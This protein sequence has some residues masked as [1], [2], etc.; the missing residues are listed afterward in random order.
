MTALRQ[1]DDAPRGFVTKAEHYRALARIEELED[2]LAES[3]G[4]AGVNPELQMRV[5]TRFG[6]TSLESEVLTLLMSHNELGKEYMFS[7]IW[8][9]GGQRSDHPEPKILD[10]Y[11]CKLRKR[12]A[13]KEAPAGIIETIWGKGWRIAPQHRAWFDAQLGGTTP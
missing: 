9:M 5:Q 1:E 3:K 12:L 13:D 11:V 10:V 8:G 6:L 4:A 7:V 2:A